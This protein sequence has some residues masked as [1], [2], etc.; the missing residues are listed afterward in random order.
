LSFF[1]NIKSFF[2]K[3]SSTLTNPSQ[4]LS[5]FFSGG[6]ASKAGIDVN[7]DTAI[8]IMAVYA[9]VRLLSETVASLPLNLNKYVKNGKERAL[10]HNL[11]NILHDIPNSEQT[12]FEFRQN[13]MVNILLCGETF[14]E[15]VRDNGGKIIELWPIPNQNVIIY[16]YLDT[17][18]LAYYEI[19]LPNGGMQRI[20]PENMWHIKGLA[21]DRVKTFNP[22]IVAREAFGLSLA[23][24]EYG[25]RFFSNGTN[26][27]GIIEYPTIVSDEAAKRFRDSTREKYEGLGKANRLMF[28]EQGS[29][30]TGVNTTN[31][32]AQ[33]LETRKFQVVEIARFFNIPPHMIMDLE[34]STNNNIE[35]QSIGFVIYSLMPWLVR[36]E[37]SI[38][39]DLLLP[40]ERKKY[41]A[42]F[43][44]NNLLRGDSAARKDFYSTMLQNGVFCP[45]DVLELEDMNTYEGGS[46]HMVNGAMIPMSGIEELYKQKLMGGVENNGQGNKVD[47]GGQLGDKTTGK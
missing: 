30:F 7:E 4:W 29:K 37:Q 12:S 32:K 43:N 41:F 46:V 14:A 20:Y 18:K 21:R 40:S 15:I 22:C 13:A 16:Y 45:N 8:K 35:N 1:G 36:I 3:R 5:D 38:F 24:E 11:Y 19:T 6:S 26:V 25:E 42:K 2:E 39:K 23:A 9:C 47:N 44:L 10:E 28:L 33:F 27:G 17:M 31:D 34:R